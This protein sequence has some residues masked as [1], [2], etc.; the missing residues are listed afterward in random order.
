MAGLVFAAIFKTCAFNVQHTM[1]LQ[2]VLIVKNCCGASCVRVFG[3]VMFGC[4][5]VFSFLAQDALSPG[6]CLSQLLAANKSRKP[7]GKSRI[8]KNSRSAGKGVLVP[9]GKQPRDQERL[10]LLV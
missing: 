1:K 8:Y 3:G 7:S 6:S 4:G 9:G 10:L 5:A 2:S